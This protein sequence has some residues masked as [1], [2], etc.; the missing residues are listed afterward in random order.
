MQVS[1]TTYS[2]FI[3]TEEKKVQTSVQG[4]PNPHND[5]YKLRKDKGKV[6]PRTGHEG[7]E[8]DLSPTGIRSQDR[9]GSVPKV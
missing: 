1:A 6:Y 7:P 4:N 5:V 8:G 3:I 2:V 9:P